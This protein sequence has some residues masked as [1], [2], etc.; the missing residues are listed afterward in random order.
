[1]YNDRYS[2]YS[3]LID[4]KVQPIRNG[5]TARKRA[6]VFKR[7]KMNKTRT[8][9]QTS[10]RLILEQFLL[11]DRTNIIGEIWRVTSY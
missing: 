8:R 10:V 11:H 4:Y 7:E 1:M 9:K 5:Y 3:R 2:A 6:R